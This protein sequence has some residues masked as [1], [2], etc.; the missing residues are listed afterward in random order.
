MKE[1]LDVA[2]ETHT[3]ME[4]KFS[5][6]RALMKSN[7]EEMRAKI[8]EIEDAEE[9]SEVKNE[10]LQQTMNKIKASIDRFEK[11]NK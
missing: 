3:E 11:T 5:E 8:K 6:E 2:A 10:Q 1:I 9:K 4:R 7:V